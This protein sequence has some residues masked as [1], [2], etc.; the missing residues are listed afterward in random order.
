MYGF[1]CLMNNLDYYQDTFGTN[2]QYIYLYFDA[3]AKHTA[4]SIPKL[5][6]VNPILPPSCV[7]LCQVHKSVNKCCH[8]HPKRKH[9][10]MN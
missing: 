8:L 6:W 9:K 3:A 2:G 1:Y 10:E 7:S 5:P 4:V